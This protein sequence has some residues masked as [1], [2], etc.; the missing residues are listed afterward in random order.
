MA[1]PKVKKEKPHDL[2]F[3]DALA[4]VMTGKSITKQE[5]A[6]KK[7][8]GLL[9]D[10]HLQICIKGVYHDWIVSDGDFYGEDWEIL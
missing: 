8:F 7:T 4:E 3:I 1:S 2:T 5:W 6:D 10:G 9:K